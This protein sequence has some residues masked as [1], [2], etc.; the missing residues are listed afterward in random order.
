MSLIELIEEF[1]VSVNENPY[2]PENYD[3]V[4]SRLQVLPDTA[5]LIN[6]IYKE[7]MK[8]FRLRQSELNNWLF[9]IRT[10]EDI[11]ERSR[12][13]YAFYETIID[14]YPTVPIMTAMLELADQLLSNE[15]ITEDKYQALVSKGLQLCG[16]D[17]VNG[18]D[19]WRISL[20]LLLQRYM[21]SKE[22]TDLDTL[23]KLHL[24][25]LSYPH[26]KLDESFEEFSSLITKYKIEDYDQLIQIANKVY[27]ETKQKLPYYEKFEIQLRE[28]PNDCAIWIEYME[29]VYKYQPNFAHVLT[30]LARATQ[31]DFSFSNQGQQLWMSVIY[32]LYASDDVNEAILTSLLERYLRTFPNSC[33]AYAE[34]IKNCIA[35]GDTGRKK[36]IDIENRI[37]AIDL[38]N[39][40]DYKDWKLVA[41][42][43]MQYKYQNELS[44]DSFQPLD[45]LLDTMVTYALE[46]KDV[47]HSVEK[48][49][50]SL[51]IS[52]GKFSH[53]MEVILSMFQAFPTE[54]SVWL[55]GIRCFIEHDV[56]QESVRE[57]FRKALSLAGKL[58]APEKL[59]E[60]WL[61]FEQVHGN[62]DSYR[63]A[64]II[65]NKALQAFMQSKATEVS[66][67]PVLHVDRKRS[68]DISEELSR[69]REEF[70]VQVN[71]LSHDV[72]DQDLKEFFAGCGEI[73][74]I[75]LVELNGI[76]QAVVEFTN[77]LEVFS[78][79]TRTHKI[80]GSN[81]VTVTRV[82]KSLLFVNNYPS[83]CS[84][85]EVREIFASIGPL[86]SIRF[87][88]QLRNKVRRFCYVQFA[89]SQD[90]EKAIS[91]YDGRSYRDEN[92]NQ[93]FAWEVK[94]SKPQERK[95]RTTPISERKVRV[96]NIAYSIDEKELRNEFSQCGEIDSIALPKAVYD[97]KKRRM[98]HNGGLA[99]IAYRDAT[100]VEDALR[101][102]G[103]ALKGR[104]INVSK[105]QPHSNWTPDDFDTLRTIG[106]VNMDP[107]LN[108]FQV[109]NFLEK[110]F[111]QVSKV[112]LLPNVGSALAEFG[113]V[114]DSGKIALG[115]STIQIDGFQ[116]QVTTKEAVVE[117]LNTNINNSGPEADPNE[118]N[119][120]PI[121]VPTSIKRRRV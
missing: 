36:F 69:S 107:S 86:V 31:T 47:F 66:S 62:I 14:D 72:T 9:E 27:S 37:R 29:S 2:A 119:T 17:F 55:Y 90:A 39:I 102:N 3:K 79:M 51:Y 89:R 70:A 33:P 105:Q 61:L 75:N 67:R 50:I 80:I 18:N 54:S 73:R 88:S 97:T 10:I 11:Q 40:S 68:H 120:K 118:V 57:T 25:R 12:L 32:M 103:V 78:A 42:A 92:L 58:D 48:L 38:R 74:T 23:I 93:E 44:N 60:E 71:N 59:T 28:V 7:K 110:N 63:K 20:N 16:Y 113:S 83:S 87:P 30:I 98:K 46:N 111:G 101:K 26:Q 99:I 84:Q 65:C 56:N 112:L 85:Q 35:L 8:Y 19:I 64:V 43:I 116:I 94:Y 1:E 100:S 77:E 115:Y 108:T 45:D 13:E 6:K 24:K 106:L 52:L 34:N 114:R 109:K 5:L 91:L 21:K 4:L 104:L 76:K 96:S 53:A 22:A 15:Q 41:L 95:D 81:E 121:L 117:V 49:A 82:E